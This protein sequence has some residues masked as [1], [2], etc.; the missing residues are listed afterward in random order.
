M[1][2]YK[3][4]KGA[5]VLEPKAEFQGCI[6]RINKEG[7]YVYSYSRLVKMFVSQGMKQEDA[8]EW[9]DYNI[10]SLK[11]MGLTISKK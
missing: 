9:V 3:L 6:L 8:V 2:Q 5:M 11:P 4:K 1:K 7:Q 10:V